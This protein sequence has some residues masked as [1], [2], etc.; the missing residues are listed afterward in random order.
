MELAFL[1]LSDWA[2]FMASSWE[3]ALFTSM[4]V[5]IKFYQIQPF[6]Q[7]T[8]QTFAEKLHLFHVC[9]H[10]ISSILAEVIKLLRVLVHRV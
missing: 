2:L 8:I 1:F 4:G 10:M 5:A 6:R 7:F 3:I 9:I